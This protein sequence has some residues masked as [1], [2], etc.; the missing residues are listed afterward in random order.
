MVEVKTIKDIDEDTWNTFKELAAKNNTKLG[1]FF[2]TMV[3][4]YEKNVESPWEIILSGKKILSTKEALQLE[5]SVK[6]VRKEYGFR[7]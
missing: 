4:E 2:K 5:K 3:K 1:N 7:V 6:E